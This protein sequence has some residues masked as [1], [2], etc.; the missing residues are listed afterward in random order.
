[1]LYKH[2]RSLEKRYQKRSNTNNR[3]GQ[4]P[5][6]ISIEMRPEI[7]DKKEKFGDLEIDIIIGKAHKGALLTINERTTGMLKMAYIKSKEAIEIERKTI[8]TSK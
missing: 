2:L 3:R 1:M 6:R 7:V 5:D 8:Q 4:I